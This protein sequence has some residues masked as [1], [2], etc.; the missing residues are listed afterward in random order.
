MTR[1]I[2]LAAIQFS[3]SDDIQGNIDRVAATISERPRKKSISPAP[4]HGKPI[5]L[6]FNWLKLRRNSAL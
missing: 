1:S 3:P 4:C 5:L 2:T 6:L